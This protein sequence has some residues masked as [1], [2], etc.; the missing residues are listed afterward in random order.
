MNADGVGAFVDSRERPTPNDGRSAG[1][2]LAAAW[3]LTVFN[4]ERASCAPD[5]RLVHFGGPSL[6][7]LSRK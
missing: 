1:L 7:L 3:I 6:I 5:S 2:Y 4:Q